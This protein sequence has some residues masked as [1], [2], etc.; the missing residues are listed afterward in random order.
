MSK[1]Q[2]GLPLVSSVLALII[3]LVLGLT[4]KH[5]LRHASDAA[6]PAPEPSSPARRHAKDSTNPES[7]RE[8]PA[9]QPSSPAPRP[10]PMIDE[11]QTPEI[12]GGQPTAARVARR[13]FKLPWRADQVVR[14]SI[15]ALSI[16]VI[17]VSALTSI[18]RPGPTQVTTSAQSLSYDVPPIPTQA[19]PGVLV[20]AQPQDPS[21]AVQYTIAYWADA[22]GAWLPVSLY[23]EDS[24][25]DED[26]TV[27]FM[28]RMEDVVPGGTQA[29]NVRHDCAYGDSYE[30]LASYDGAGN[31]TRTL[32]EEGPGSSIPDALLATEDGNFKLWGGSFASAEAVPSAGDLCL[33]QRSQKLD[34]A[35]A[36][37]ITVRS[38]TVYMLWEGRLAPSKD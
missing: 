26:K 24:P 19:V 1:Q 33:P 32:Y 20:E 2:T 31:T 13:G 10:A 16:F 18:S 9:P 30:L 5:A 36:I 14:G 12:V 27:P 29:F 7:Q 28:L 35:Y 25:D 38:E 17:V 21:Q 4:I 34:E 15:W 23:P 11:S 22:F 6:D 8:R 3:G 37:A